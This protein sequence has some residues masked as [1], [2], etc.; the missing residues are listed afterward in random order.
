M[1]TPSDEVYQKHLSALLNRLEGFLRLWCVVLMT[2][3]GFALD[4][5][6]ERL[7]GNEGMVSNRPGEDDFGLVNVAY[8]EFEKTK[9]W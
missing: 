4:L 5:Q 1:S 9:S 7:V 3:A 8:M 2:P 6:E